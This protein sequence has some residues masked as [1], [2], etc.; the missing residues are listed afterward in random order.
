M[1]KF[2]PTNF[3]QILSQLWS[4]LSTGIW[5]RFSADLLWQRSAQKT[6]DWQV[7]YSPPARDGTNIPLPLLSTHG[8]KGGRSKIRLP[9][10]PQQSLLV[11]THFKAVASA[12]GLIRI[13]NRDTE[14][15]IW[16]LRC[17]FKVGTPASK[18]KVHHLQNTKSR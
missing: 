10:A 14:K 9:S 16:P 6:P 4:R 12:L 13:R 18:K 17:H 11:K 1:R 2:L 8:S 3:V 7:L 5:I 15:F